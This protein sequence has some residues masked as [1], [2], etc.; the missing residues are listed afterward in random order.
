[1][2]PGSRYG[3]L[4][5]QLR[6]RGCCFIR[7]EK[8]Q[9]GRRVAWH[10]RADCPQM[11]VPFSSPGPGVTSGPVARGPEGLSQAPTARRHLRER[12]RDHRS[13]R[14]SPRPR[15]QSGSPHQVAEKIPLPSP[16]QNCGPKREVWSRTASSERPTST[17]A[18]LVLPAR[19]C[20]TAMDCGAGPRVLK[21]SRGA[22]V[23]LTRSWAGDGVPWASWTG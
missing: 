19:P 20:G 12:P 10:E 17:R 9:V 18:S 1:M 5:V 22:V 14:T 21:R 23:V 2:G 13:G 11:F 7:D 15:K 6:C 16:A 3:S 4:S 8:T